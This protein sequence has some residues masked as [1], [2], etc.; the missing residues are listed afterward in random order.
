MNRNNFVEFT[1]KVAK[2]A[3]EYGVTG[4]WDHS[5]ADGSYFYE[6]EVAEIAY[7]DHNELEQVYYDYLEDK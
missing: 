1:N 2:L 6:T 3:E 5:T 4:G 7:K